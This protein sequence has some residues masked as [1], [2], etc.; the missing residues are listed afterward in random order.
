MPGSECQEYWD[1]VDQL[2][3]SNYTLILCTHK[4]AHFLPELGLSSRI[5]LSSGWCWKYRQSVVGVISIWYLDEWEVEDGGCFEDEHGLTL[6]GLLWR[7]LIL[8]RNLHCRWYVRATWTLWNCLAIYFSVFVAETPCFSV[9]HCL[10]KICREIVAPFEFL[11]TFLGL[12]MMIVSLDNRIEVKW[13]IFFITIRLCLPSESFILAVLSE[14]KGEYLINNFAWYLIYMKKL[15]VSSSWSAIKF[16]GIISN[17]E[18]FQML[19]L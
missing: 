15:L 18:F 12:Y 14:L 10:F 13:F 1:M 8:E 7:C 2:N 16:F 11:V 3:F 6:F 4:V 5:P 17:S 19:K 9:D